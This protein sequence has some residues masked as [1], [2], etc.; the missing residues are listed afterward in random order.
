MIPALAEREKNRMNLHAFVF[1]SIT[2]IVKMD[3]PLRLVIFI[4]RSLFIINELLSESENE[5]LFKVYPSKCMFI[6]R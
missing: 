5:V 6:Y 1:L 2:Y 3:C 4:Y